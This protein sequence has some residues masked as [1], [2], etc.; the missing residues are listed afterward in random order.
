VPQPHIVPIL[1]EEAGL[2][3]AEAVD[4]WA[5]WCDGQSATA[6]GNKRGVSQ[7]AVSANA[8][9]AMDELKSDLDVFC[10]IVERLMGA[11]L[12]RLESDR[13][14]S[15]AG[16]LRTE[17]IEGAQIVTVYGVDISTLLDSFD[18]RTSLAD[19]PQAELR[20][21]WHDIVGSEKPIVTVSHEPK[22]SEYI[23]YVNG[24]VRVLDD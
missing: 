3:P 19:G 21:Y 20:A 2:T 13:D 24:F 10:P 17:R 7:Q 23:L 22:T 8:E 11:T 4:Y 18:D 5:V 14:I 16:E 6:W 15:I 9:R 1:I 12:E